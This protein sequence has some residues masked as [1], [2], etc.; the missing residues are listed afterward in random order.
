MPIYNY[1]LEESFQLNQNIKTTTSTYLYNL[2]TSKNS[3][4]N[5]LYN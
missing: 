3:R 5:K 4:H 1:K 2:N